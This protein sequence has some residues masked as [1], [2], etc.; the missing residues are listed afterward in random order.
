MSDVPRN[1]TDLYTSPN[2]TGS[3]NMDDGS[4]VIQDV[5]CAD[6]D[7][8]QLNTKGKKLLVLFEPT[9]YLNLI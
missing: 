4:D 5:N 1:E 9:H 6:S 7:C 2:E 3:A 8:Q